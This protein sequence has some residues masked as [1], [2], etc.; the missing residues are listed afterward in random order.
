MHVK[1]GLL[2]PTLD[3]L[4]IASQLKIA[5]TY[6][7]HRTYQRSCCQKEKLQRLLE[8]HLRQTS[9][10]QGI[11][12]WSRICTVTRSAGNFWTPTEKCGGVYY[13]VDTCSKK[14]YL[15]AVATSA[16]RSPIPNLQRRSEMHATYHSIQPSPCSKRTVYPR[17]VP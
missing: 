9:T 4:E 15:A 6:L 10:R 5:K 7:T 1:G 11:A 16:H 3:S 2:L 13:A 14:T 17:E 12:T 8:P